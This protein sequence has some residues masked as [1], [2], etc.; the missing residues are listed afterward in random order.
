MRHAMRLRAQV[1]LRRE[2][3]RGGV[4]RYASCTCT[5]HLRNRGG[6][7]SAPAGDVQGP[8]WQLFKAGYAHGAVVHHWL[9]RTGTKFKCSRLLLGHDGHPCSG[10]LLHLVM[11][12]TR[13]M[14]VG[15]V[16]LVLTGACQFGHGVGGFTTNFI[17]SKWYFFPVHFPGRS[18]LSRKWGAKKHRQNRPLVVKAQG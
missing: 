13:S 7:L 9:K 8:D 11:V 10:A 6:P 5:G 14:M 4:G 17:H 3:G 2:S 18:T 12:T 1:A 15:W 16:F